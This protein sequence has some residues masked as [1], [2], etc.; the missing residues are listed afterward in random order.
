MSE[1]ETWIAA[2]GVWPVHDDIADA[3]IPEHVLNDPALS[4]IAKGLFA[5]LVAE[6]GRPVNP[7]EDSYETPAAITEAVEEL[8][9]TGLAVRVQH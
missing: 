3:V 4:L 7:Y 6:K 5:L 8:I 1:L 9:S 2:T